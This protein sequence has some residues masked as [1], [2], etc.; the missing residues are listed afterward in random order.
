MITVT[1]RSSVPLK[2]KIHCGNLPC[3]GPPHG[4]Q[5]AMR[6]KTNVRLVEINASLFCRVRDAALMADGTS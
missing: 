2:T 3:S 1:N 4:N 5:Y 6:D